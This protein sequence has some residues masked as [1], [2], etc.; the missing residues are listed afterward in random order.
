MHASQRIPKKL[1]KTIN[2]VLRKDR[3]SCLSTSTGLTD[4]GFL[5]AFHTKVNTM[6]EHLLQQPAFCEITCE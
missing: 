4:D 3:H 5:T 2:S 6:S 1:W